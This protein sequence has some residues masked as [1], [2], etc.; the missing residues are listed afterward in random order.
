MEKLVIHLNLY[1]KRNKNISVTLTV[2]NNFL[3]STFYLFF[4]RGKNLSLLTLKWITDIFGSSQFFCCDRIQNVKHLLY[5]NNL[6][7]WMYVCF[8]I[9]DFWWKR[10]PQYEHGYGLVSLCIKRCVDNVD[11]LL[12][13]FA[14]I[15]HWKQ[16]EKRKLEKIFI[17]NKLCHYIIKRYFW[18]AIFKKQ[19]KKTKIL[20]RLLKLSKKYFIGSVDVAA[21]L[22]IIANLLYVAYLF[23][24]YK[25]TRSQFFFW[26]W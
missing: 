4:Q 10:F 25:Q 9:S 22:F 2:T 11:D 1:F 12:K 26:F 6:P 18:L 13:V 17:K 14:H 16:N 24:C 7:V 15:L 5:I 23:F 21:F 3:I 8:F 19:K 20:L